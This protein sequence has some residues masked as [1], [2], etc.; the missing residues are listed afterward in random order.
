MSVKEPHPKPPSEMFVRAVT[1]GGGL[2]LTCELCGRECFEDSESA[3]DW[4]PGEL[5]N[6]RQMQKEDPE[7]YVGLDTVCTGYINGR[8]VVT[9]CPCNLLRPLEDWIWS[10]RDIIASYISKRVDEMVQSVEMEKVT[11]TVLS[12]AVKQEARN[13]NAKP[14]LEIFDEKPGVRKL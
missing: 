6:L 11:A 3:G 10:H 14:A 7:K 8:Q 5:E 13:L 2:W 4:D 12:E 9:N 1:T